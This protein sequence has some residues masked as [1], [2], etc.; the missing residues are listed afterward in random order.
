MQSWLSRWEGKKLVHGESVL[1]NP[2]WFYFKYISD[3]IE[4]TI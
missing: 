2:L 4:I 3:L 1:Q